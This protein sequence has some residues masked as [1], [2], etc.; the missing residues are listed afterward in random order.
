MD[1]RR[2]LQFLNGL[3]DLESG[4]VRRQWRAKTHSDWVRNLTWQLPKIATAFKTENT[5]PD[6]VEADRNNR[7]VH[8]FHDAFKSAAKRKHLTD[9]CH[10]P[11]GEDANDLARLDRTGGAAK[12]MNQVAR[13]LLGRNRDAAHRAR[14]G[15]NHGMSVDRLI[16]QKA[17]GAIGG[18]NQQQRVHPGHM[19]DDKQ[20]APAFRYVVTAL[21]ADSIER[22]REH[23]QR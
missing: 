23:P 11:L 22:M 13:P 19:V 8:A 1:V 15:M 12:R 9:A 6:I 2:G 16:H 4:R 14:E 18:C 20:R 21:Y 5:S 10:L 7:S 3:S 17:D